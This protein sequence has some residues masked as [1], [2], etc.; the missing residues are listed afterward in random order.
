MNTIKFT[1]YNSLN[2]PQNIIL[3]TKDNIEVLQKVNNS[4]YYDKGD[5]QY[6]TWPSFITTKY[7]TYV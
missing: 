1:N 6:R 5:K 2:I 3:K 4:M 7:G